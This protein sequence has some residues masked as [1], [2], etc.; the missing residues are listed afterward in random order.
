MGVF[1]SPPRA[2][3]VQAASQLGACLLPSVLWVLLLCWG[4]S[5]LPRGAYVL[6]V[7]WVEQNPTAGAPSCPAPLSD[8]SSQ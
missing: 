1:P 5:L 7:H 3:S 2:G 4:Q 8:E 6:S